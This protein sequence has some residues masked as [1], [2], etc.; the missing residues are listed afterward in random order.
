MKKYIFKCPECKSI[1][2]L[3]TDLDSE[4]YIQKYPP[5]I[6]GKNA[7]IPLNSP[8]YAYGRF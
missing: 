4:R 5:C 2:S 3:E 6:C 1:M 8:E 7:M